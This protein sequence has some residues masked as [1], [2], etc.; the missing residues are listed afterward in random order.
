MKIVADKG[1]VPAIVDESE[2]PDGR[3]ELLPRIIDVQQFAGHADP[4]TTRLYDRRG[5]KINR[6]LVE[7]IYDLKLDYGSS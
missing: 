7:R 5:R 6:N 1:A 4:R 3:R 2:V